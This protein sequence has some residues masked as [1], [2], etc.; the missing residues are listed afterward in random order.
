MLQLPARVMIDRNAVRTQNHTRLLWL[1]IILLTAV[2]LGTAAGIL[3]WMGGLPIALA[4]LT[5]GSTFAGVIVVCL[6]VAAYLS[7]PSS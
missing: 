6:A 4:I 1:A 2:I 5:G 7:Q 3:A